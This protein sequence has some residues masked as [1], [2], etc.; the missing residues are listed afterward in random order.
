MAFLF[1][2]LVMDRK[3][4]NQEVWGMGGLGGVVVLLEDENEE[5]RRYSFQGNNSVFTGKPACL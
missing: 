2:E 4:P 3:I 5:F 1:S